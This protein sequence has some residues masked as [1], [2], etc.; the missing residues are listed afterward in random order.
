MGDF[1]DFYLKT[2]AQLLADV[3]EKF[4]NRRLEF[5]K[6]DPSCY[7]SSPGLSWHSMLKMTGVKLKLISQTSFILL[8]KN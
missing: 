4:I 6:L 5:N 1:H 2:D 7:L 3:S 8:K